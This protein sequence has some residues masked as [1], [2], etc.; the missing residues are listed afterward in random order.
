MT[1]LANSMFNGPINPGQLSIVREIKTDTTAG[2][3]DTARFQGN[4]SGV[5]LL[6][7]SRRAGDRHPCGRG[8]ARRH[9]SA[10]Q[11]REGPVRRRQRAQHHRR[12]AGNDVALNG[13]A[14]DDLILGLAGTDTLNGCAATT[15]LSAARAPTRS[16][17]YADNFDNQSGNSTGTANWASAWVETGDSGASARARS[18]STTATI[19]S[20]AKTTVI[21]TGQPSSA[22]HQPRRRDQP[23]RSASANQDNLDAGEL[24]LAELLQTNQRVTIPAITS[25]GANQN[26]THS[27][28]TG[29]FTTASLRFVASGPQSLRRMTS[30]TSTIL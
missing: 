25:N 27:R 24:V 21:P 22:R 9:R 15:S 17:T 1:T 8:R 30:S 5:R 3:I 26:G 29:P 2:D 6:R 16:A 23:P 18:A 12:H 10:A 14:Q 19:P 20:V 13:T 4:R 11:H 7:N 28:A